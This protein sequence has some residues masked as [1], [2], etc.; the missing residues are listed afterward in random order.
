MPEPSHKEHEGVRASFM[1]KVSQKNLLNASG[2]LSSVANAFPCAAQ[3]SWVE[4]T[5]ATLRQRRCAQGAPPCRK[6]SSFRSHRQPISRC[7]T[8]SPSRADSMQSTSADGLVLNATGHYVYRPLPPRAMTGSLES[9]QMTTPAWAMHCGDGGILLRRPVLA[10]GFWLHSRAYG[11]ENL[12]SSSL[13]VFN[14]PEHD[15]YAA[16]HRSSFCW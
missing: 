9:A 4:P 14:L 5:R 3:S 12:R 15:T 1:G 2:V 13:S 11:T 7:N 16:V 6:Y 8:N 10:I